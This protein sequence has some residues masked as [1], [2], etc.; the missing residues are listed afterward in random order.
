MVEFRIINMYVAKLIAIIANIILIIL[1]IKRTEKLL[2]P[3]KRIIILQIFIDFSL[4][5][6]AVLFQFVSLEFSVF[7]DFSC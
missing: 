4:S 3:Y 2:L 5:V 1:V 7:F 6:V